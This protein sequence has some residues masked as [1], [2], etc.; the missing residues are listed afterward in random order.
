MNDLKKRFLA[1]R[2]EF[3]ALGDV[4]IMSLAVE[5]MRYSKS[6]ILRAFNELVSKDEYEQDEKGEIVNYLFEYS[7][8]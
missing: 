6:T 8:K 7:I 1:F 3:P 4:I 5:N 2:E